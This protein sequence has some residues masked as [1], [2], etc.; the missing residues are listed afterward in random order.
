MDKYI[1]SVRSG[2]PEKEESVSSGSGSVNR[3]APASLPCLY[4][5]NC[6]EESK[7]SSENLCNLLS[8]Y[9]RKAAHTL[10]ENVAALVRTVG[11]ERIGFLTLT[12][13]DNVTDHR[14]ALKRFRSMNSHY[15]APHLYFGA[16]LCVKERQRRGAWHYHLLID[17][18]GDIRTGIV[19]EEIKIGVYRSANDH[20]RGLWGDLRVN[21]RKY[22][23]GRSELLPIRENG[24]AMAKYVGKYVSKHVGSR[25]EEDKGVRTVSYSQSW[26]RSNSNF[27]WHTSNSWSWRRNV[28]AFAEYFGCGS[29]TAL[30]ERFGPRWAYHYADVIIGNDWPERLAEK[31]KKC[32]DQEAPCPGERSNSHKE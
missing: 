1:P 27:Q 13:S 3:D 22:G 14:E 12:F 20:L 19:W 26:P 9:H 4:S 8:P 7:S 31:E 15:L 17:S 21:L 28:A 16:W 2:Q 25:K 18:G 10:A 5:N 29:L 23:F 30:K 6:T 11:L 24:E 32:P